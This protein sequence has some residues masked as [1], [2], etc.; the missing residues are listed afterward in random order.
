M[1]GGKLGRDYTINYREALAS[2]SDPHMGFQVSGTSGNRRAVRRLLFNPTG[3]DPESLEGWKLRWARLPPNCV[4]EF[5]N[6]SSIAGG[7]LTRSQAMKVLDDNIREKEWSDASKR[8]A[9][10]PELEMERARYRG[11]HI[12]Q[13]CKEH[14]NKTVVVWEWYHGK[15]A[16]AW[17]SYCGEECK[18]LEKVHAEL[19][20]ALLN[21]GKPFKN[22]PSRPLKILFN[23]IWTKEGKVFA[24]H[25]QIDMVTKNRRGVRRKSKLSD[26]RD[27]IYYRMLFQYPKVSAMNVYKVY[28]QYITAIARDPANGY[29]A[30]FKQA[31]IALEELQKKSLWAAPP[32][33]E[34]PDAF[35]CPLKLSLM[36]EPAYSAKNTKMHRIERESLERWVKS[37][38]NNPMTREPMTVADIVVDTKLDDKMTQW[39]WTFNRTE[40]PSAATASSEVAASS[41]AAASSAAATPFPKPELESYSPHQLAELKVEVHR[42]LSIPD[43]SNMTIK[44]I[45]QEVSRRMKVDF[46]TSPFRKWFRSVIREF[47]AKR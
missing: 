33:E 43:N 31:G 10:S 37:H 46:N 35:V 23:K 39:M 30:A 44:Q 1:S 25:S 6:M 8:W 19:D 13:F 38:S 5:F 32:Q 11:D 7:V 42:V 2:V 29:A 26:S 41:S 22:F 45:R 16:R 17:K 4:A 27:Y 40:R 14:G 47:A 9:G 21:G 20:Y 15:A 34:I 3:I 12:Q 24:F 36:L 18:L 28:T